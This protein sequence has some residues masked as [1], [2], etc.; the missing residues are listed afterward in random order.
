[1]YAI[2]F[3]KRHRYEMIKCDNIS[4]SVLFQWQRLS[5]CHVHI[6]QK[7]KFRILM[8]THL[9]NNFHEY[10]TEKPQD[11]QT[12]KKIV[13]KPTTFHQVDAQL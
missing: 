11:T 10:D 5:E 13:G 2:Y 1:M 6:S 12:H 9:V 8:I 4:I 3:N 7:P